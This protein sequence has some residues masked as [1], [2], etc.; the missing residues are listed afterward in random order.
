MIA[1]LEN[2]FNITY[3]IIKCLFQIPRCQ[4]VM[5]NGA[6]SSTFFLAP[7]LYFISRLF[8]KKFIFRK[9]G[10]AFEQMLEDASPF[11]KKVC[12]KT[13]FQ[14]DLFLVE[15]KSLVNILLKFEKYEN[16]HSFQKLT[17]FQIVLNLLNKIFV[18]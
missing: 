6:Q 15:T 2:V 8:R 7:I 16:D 10:G 18:S 14:S 12:R 11:T 4:V 13:I 9:F 1:L 3:V 17:L 5:V